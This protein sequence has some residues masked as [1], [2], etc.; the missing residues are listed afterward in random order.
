MI[1]ALGNVKKY[2][3]VKSFLNVSSQMMN[4]LHRMMILAI[5]SLIS[6]LLLLNL[7]SIVK[8]V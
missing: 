1:K 4:V 3:V 6:T 5:S 7:V 8:H 2:S